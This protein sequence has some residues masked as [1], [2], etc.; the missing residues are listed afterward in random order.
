MRAENENQDL[1]RKIR[2]LEVYLGQSQG[3]NQWRKGFFEVTRSIF[4]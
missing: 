2:E 3:G 1:Q 4:L